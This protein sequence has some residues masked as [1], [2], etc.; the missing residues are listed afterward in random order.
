MT[1]AARSARSNS[2]SLRVTGTVTDLKLRDTA[3]AQGW[4]GVSQADVTLSIAAGAAVGGL[5]GAAIDVGQFPAGSVIRIDNSGTISGKAGTAGTSGVG[6][7]GGDA[8]NASYGNQTVTITNNAAGVIRGG[9]GGGGKG[10]QGGTG[11]QGGQG[12]S[13]SSVTE[14][15]SNTWGGFSNYC[16]KWFANGTLQIFWGTTLVYSGADPGGSDCNAGGWTY[17]R[18]VLRGNNAGGGGEGATD[19]T[20]WYYAVW[21][22]SYSRQYFDGGAGGTGGVGGNGGVG[23]GHTVTKASGSVG[24]GGAGGSAGGTNAGAGGTGGTGGTGGAGGDWGAAGSAG[25]AGSTGATGNAGNS[26]S[27]AGGFSG[28]AGYAGGAAGK[29]IA[30]GTANLTVTNNGSILGAVT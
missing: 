28:Q 15:D 3:V 17:H 20:E 12:Y 16:W 18:G 1:F 9:G 21:R 25:T 2:F 22:T 6:G 10:G 30:K 7:A 24:S 8:I 29:A 23:Q 27:G 13:D 4:D 26:T 5:T 19:A 11:G 14:G